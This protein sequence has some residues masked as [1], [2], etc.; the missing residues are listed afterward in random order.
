MGGWK[1]KRVGCVC[2]YLQ[3]AS[4]ASVIGAASAAVFVVVTQK[5]GKCY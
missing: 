1:S 3:F 5:I 4:P 2:I